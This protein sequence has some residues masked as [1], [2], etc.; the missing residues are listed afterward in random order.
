MERESHSNLDIMESLLS[1]LE[2]KERGAMMERDSNQSYKFPP[3]S[4]IK[5]NKSLELKKLESNSTAASNNENSGLDSP[6]GLKKS[7]DLNFRGKSVSYQSYITGEQT[8]LK[9]LKKV[10]RSYYW[11][12]HELSILYMVNIHFFLFIKIFIFFF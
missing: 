3:E 10:K 2:S 7:G 9:E 11:K 12:I 1:E 6:K 8:N 4:Q 5:I